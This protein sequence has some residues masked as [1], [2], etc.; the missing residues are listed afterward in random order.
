MSILSVD[1]ISPIGSGTSVTVNNAATLVVNNINVSGVSTFSDI[2]DVAGSNSTIRLGNG[3]NRR[4]MYRSGD[5]DIVLEAA[6]NFFYRQNISD[7]SHRWYTNGADEKV[8]ITGAGALQIG[9]LQTSQNSTTHTSATKLH[10]DSTKSIKIARLAA[11]NITSAGWYTV[12]KVAAQ[13]GNYFKCYASI[14]GDFTQDMCVIELTGSYSA[15]GGLQNTYAE[16]VFKAHRTGAHSTD[17]ITRARFVKDSSNITYL[18]IYIAGGV[19]NNTW[20]KSVLEYQIGAYSQNTADSGSAAMFAAGASV[21]NIRTLEVDDNAIC[22]SSGSHKFYSGGNATQRVL[23][24]A[25][26]KIG[27]NKN[28]PTYSLDIVGDQINFQ[29]NASA[30]N[31]V[32]RLRGQNTSTGGAIV[33]MNSAGNSGPLELWN[34]SNKTF[35][36][37]TSGRVTKPYH[38]SF[39]VRRSTGGDG[40]AAQDPVTEWANPG[41]SE[42]SGN[43]V[44]NRGGH[45][46][47]S[48]G[49]FTAPVSGIYHFSAAAGYKQSSVDFNQK[50]VLNG[51]EM[52]EGVRFIGSPPNSHS[53]GTIS[54]TCY[55]A[56]GNTM[57]VKIQTTHHANT[58]LNFFSGHFIG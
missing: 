46:N 42:S 13:N 40:R 44:H 5:N 17:R 12:A 11:G 52:A 1:N 22:V 15:S 25:N 39:Y 10:I 18:Q 8:I 27:I 6:A 16:P 30:S 3:A 7:T 34:G 28:S 36:I 21:T 29:S 35:N 37:D 49:L 41:T 47:Y 51:G 31:A 4:L 33:A 45:F 19:N 48:T 54:A 26:G 57:G 2:V 38:P 14:G 43:P 58:T 53:T 9:N 50:F 56:S 32:V 23:I 55:M 24:D 20:G